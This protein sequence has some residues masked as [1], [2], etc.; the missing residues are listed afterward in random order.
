VGTPILGQ[1]GH[2]PGALVLGTSP[3]GHGPRARD[4]GSFLLCPWPLEKRFFPKKLTFFGFLTGVAA[5]IFQ[6]N[7]CP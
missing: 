3:K 6:T 7:F 2:G 5:T 4:F 1:K